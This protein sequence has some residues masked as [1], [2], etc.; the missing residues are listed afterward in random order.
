MNQG[1]IDTT[2][3]QNFAREH[4]LVE[5]LLDL[6]STPARYHNVHWFFSYVYNPKFA[7]EHKL[8]NDFH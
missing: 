6:K 2:G 8:M 3:T 1:V 7:A 4:K 5:L